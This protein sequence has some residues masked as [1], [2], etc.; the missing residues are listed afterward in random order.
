MIKYG[1]DHLGSMDKLKCHDC[2]TEQ[3]RSQLVDV[4]NFDG[5]DKNGEAIL[6]ESDWG[7]WCCKSLNVEEVR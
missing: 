2:G 3:E 7:C 5:Y 6:V 1:H 4:P